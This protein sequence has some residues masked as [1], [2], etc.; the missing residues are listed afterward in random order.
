MKLISVS[1]LVTSQIRIHARPQFIAA[2]YADYA[3][4]ISAVLFDWFEEYFNHTYS[5]SKTGA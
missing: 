3:A 2:G 1:A 4:N 5:F